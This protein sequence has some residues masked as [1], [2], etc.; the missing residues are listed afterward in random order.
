MRKISTFIYQKSSWTVFII[1]VAITAPLL[2]RTLSYM[3]PIN[4]GQGLLDARALGFV[5]QEAMEYLDQIGDEGKIVYKRFYT[6]LHDVVPPLLGAVGLSVLTSLAWKD[7]RTTPTQQLLNLVP[8]V[9][10]LLDMTE[11]LLIWFIIEKHPNKKEI[12]PL[13]P[14]TSGIVQLKYACLAASIIIIIIGFG[15]QFSDYIYKNAKE[16][17][18]LQNMLGQTQKRKSMRNRRIPRN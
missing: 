6:H 17:P 13:A 2:Y 18:A 9:T 14:F 7:K 10:F 8:F 11:N 4:V 16:F 3:A 5:V 1:L 12:E 15:K